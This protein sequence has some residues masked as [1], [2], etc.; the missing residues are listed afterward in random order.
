MSEY[1]LD[2][3]GFAPPVPLVP[4]S[5]SESSVETP[6]DGRRKCIS[7][8]RRMSEKSAD[9]HTLCIT[10]RGFDCDLN[11]RCEECLEWSEEEV[12]KYAKYRKSLKSRESSSRAKTSV[13]TS[14]LTPSGHSPQPAPQPAPR[15]AQRDDIQSQVDSLAMNFKSLSDNLT[16]QLS[17]FMTQ[18][19]CQNQSSRQPRLGPDAGESHPGRT[20]GESRMFQGE[21][22]PSRTPLVPPY[23]SYPLPSDSRAP[24]PEQSGRA[25]PHS[26]PFAAPR[27]STCQAPRPPPAFEAPPQPSTSGWVPT[28]PPPPR[29]RH[30]SSASDSEASEGESVTSARD[31][32]SARLAYLFYE[33]CPDSR[34]LFDPKAPR[35]G[36][37]AWFGQ[38]E[39]AASKQC[40]RLYPRV[41]EVQEEVAA[42]SES[43]AR[44]SKPLS[45]VIPASARTY[46]LADDAVFASSQPVNSAFAQLAGSRALG[47]RRWGS[48]TFSDMERLERLFQGQL[49]VTSSSLWLMSGI[50]AML[51]R[52][53]FQP[54]DPALS[55]VSAAL[56]RQART[57]AAG[58]GFLRAK[59]RESLLAH[60]SLPVPESQK[61]S[62]TTIPGSSS[63]LFDTELLTEVVS[64]IQSSSQ[65][66][67]NLALSRSLRRGRSAPSSSSTPLTGLRLSSFAH[68]R[69]YGK[70]SSSSSGSGG[71]KGGGL[72]L[73]DL[74]VSGGRSHLLSGPFPAV[75]CPS[76][77]RPGG[78]GVRS[79]GW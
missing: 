55:S 36:F 17:D 29:S 44:R 60:T 61:R 53:H 43:L 59:R 3:P 49:E 71:R 5:S 9:Q 2:E 70:R 46:A 47:S 58:S 62:L 4:P 12:I 13:S 52:D 73:P 66:S 28:G 78:T 27:A 23:H 16:S 42:R 25:T 74:R 30:D 41:A 67:S 37:E 64:Q 15:P 14:P 20:A 51:K 57:A 63:G 50:L 35:C 11:N 69:P 77:G 26:P 48:V 72:L 31:S 65:I 79:R 75:V 56:S 76:I 7:C 8:P 6:F 24:L 1:S 33:V 19:L 45:R 32:A 10:C 40:F 68:G 22:A 38:P 18:F 39:A 34:P 54:S 21:G